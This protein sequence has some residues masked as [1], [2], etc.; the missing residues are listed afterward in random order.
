LGRSDGVRGF[1]SIQWEAVAKTCRQFTNQN[2]QD[3]I[4]GWYAGVDRFCQAEHAFYWG[5]TG[6]AYHNVCSVD[7]SAIFLEHYQKGLVAYGYSASIDRL[8]TKVSTLS[9]KIEKTIGLEEKKKLKNQVR[10]LKDQRLSHR[11]EIA[12]LESAIRSKGL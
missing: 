5:K 4:G 8:N 12:R 10:L 6:Q 3:Y 7:R 2:H 9:L 1:P 11:K